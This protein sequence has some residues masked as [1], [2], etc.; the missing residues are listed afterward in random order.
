MEE[1]WNIFTHNGKVTVDSPT[2]THHVYQI[3]TQSK[4]SKFAPGQR[5]LSIRQGH[6]FVGFAFVDTERKKVNLFN[7]FKE[8]PT[9]IGHARVLIN[10][11]HYKKLGLKYLIE[12]RCRVCNRELTD[13][14]SIEEG[15]G[16]ICK[17]K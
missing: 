6:N 3:K 2:G 10:I 17:K 9:Y 13:P 11:D 5:L 7:R 1:H 12:G 4:K 16:P 15:I 14:V 8:N